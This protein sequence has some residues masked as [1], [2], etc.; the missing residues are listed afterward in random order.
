MSEIHYSRSTLQGVSA[1]RLLLSLIVLVSLLA[2]CSPA[3]RLQRLLAHHPELSVVDS[4]HFKD[5]VIVPGLK[6]DTSVVFMNK[7]DSIVLHKDS[8]HLVVKQVHDTFVIHSELERDTIYINRTVPVSKIKIVK[9]SFLTTFK[10]MLPWLVIGLI[11]FTVL[12]IV[13]HSW[14]RK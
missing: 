10:S 12:T 7:I 4:L 3:T 14:F 2:S 6:I 1:C 13:I 8:F 5:T 9:P 11:T